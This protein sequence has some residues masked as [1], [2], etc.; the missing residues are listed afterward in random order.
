MK[1]LITSLSIVIALFWVSC[2]ESNQAPY[3]GKMFELL[4]PAQTGITFSNTIQ[5]SQDANYLVYE[6]F[7]QGAGVAAG[8][9]NNDGLTDLYFCGNMA[10]NRLYMNRGDWKFE[11]VTEQA[12]VDG[13]DGWSDGVALGDVN[14]DG[15]LDIYV[16]KFL[17]DDESLRHNLLYINNGDGTFSEQA[18]QWGVDD[19]GYSVQAAF[20]DYDRDG[21][22]DLYVVNQPPNSS[23]L[24]KE[25]IGYV[26][27]QY[28]DRLYRNNGDGSFTDVTDQAGITNYGYGLSV[29]IGDLDNDHWPD[30]YVACDYE[31]PDFMYINNHDGTFTDRSKQSLRHM[32]NYGMGCDAADFNNDGNL[33]IYVADMVAPDNYRLK[34]NMS[35]M[36]PQKFWTLAQAGYHYQYMFNT[37]QLN[38][39][40][41]YFSE[42]AQLAGVSATDWSWS[43]LFADLDNDGWKDLLVTN[44]MLR[45]VRNNDFK[46]KMMDK[47]EEQRKEAEEKGEDFVP[48]YL[49][50]LDMAPSVKLSDYLFHNKGDLTF[51]NMT[52]DWGLAKPG[53]DH[54]VALADLDNDGDL[55]IVMNSLNDTARIFQNHATEKNG[56]HWIRFDLKGNKHN[57][58]SYGARVEIYTPDGGYQVVE[59]YPNRGYMSASE[60]FVHFGIGENKTV[61][62]AVIHW[63]DGNM[64][65][66]DGLKADKI[67]TADVKDARLEREG[68]HITINPLFADITSESKLKWRHRENEFDDYARES[69]IPYQLSRLGP[70]LATGDLNGDQVEDIYAGGAIGQPGAIFLQKPDGTFQYWQLHFFDEE[71]GYE[72][73]GAAIFDA[74]G[75]GDNDLY[76]ASG[77]NEY[78]RGSPM[79]Q[80][81]LYINNGDGTFHKD[82]DALPDLTES[83]GC[84]R[85]FDF[86][87][88][89][90]IDLFVGGRQHPGRYPY[91]ARSYLLRNDGGTFTD[92][93]ET[94]APDLLKPGMVTDAVWSDYDGDG[95]TDLVIVGEWMP[96]MLLHNDGNGFSN[97]TT[98]SGLD[99]YTG[100]WYC[101]S[102]ADIDQ[103][104]DEDFL[105]GNLGLNS[106]YK[107]SAEEPFSVYCTDFD[108]NG[109]YDI[110]LSYY[111][112]GNPYPVRGRTCSSNQ[113]PYLKKKFPTYDAFASATLDKIYGEKLK[114]ALHYDAH[115]FESVYL[116]NKGNNQFE[117]HPLPNLAQISTVMGIIPYDFDQDGNMDIVLAGN[118]YAREVET[119]RNDAGYGLYLKGDGAGHFSPVPITESGFFAPGDVHTL[120][121]TWTP[122]GFPLVLIGKNN[123]YLQAVAC[124]KRSGSGEGP[125]KFKAKVEYANT[126]ADAPVTENT[127]TITWEIE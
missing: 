88:D 107:A 99:K 42:I 81:R 106:K 101:I 108:G 33:D 45:D 92:V 49:S 65:E 89:G 28:T 77:G 85:P 61:D 95:A 18:A 90:D 1:K 74:D 12:G 17:W 84:V 29:A 16:C 14:G 119:E 46:H 36:N 62:K 97:Q 23:R 102:S 76:V 50:I 68:E 27:F 127:D 70:C 58:F 22:L 73:L 109:T 72:D 71:K 78:D 110:V 30:I 26:D 25:L 86:D 121:M 87:G 112:N 82:T 103:D 56:N 43:A 122:E 126:W 20:L 5:E 9:F 114:E 66:M 39:G 80:D 63:P 51:E 60:L 8:D 64:L 19:A 98:A 10:P 15:W 2:Q 13:G 105:I 38:N 94:L 116:E 4:K 115:I 34:A 21:D 91:P 67:Y 120:V 41:R 93:T 59:H 47:L 124:T 57:P 54:G 11:D 3:T 111:N 7:Y 40:N 37:L 100:W 53:W 113:M 96:I 52:T 44:G 75:D 118:L 24:K 48:D 6:G 69:L 31:A 83:N 35:G 123:D 55:D 117:L 104:G 32:S 79:L 125:T